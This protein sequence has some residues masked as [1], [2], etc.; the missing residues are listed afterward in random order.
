MQLTDFNASGRSLF[1]LVVRAD[2]FPWVF[3]WWLLCEKPIELILKQARSLLSHNMEIFSPV[4]LKTGLIWG[5]YW[6]K[7]R[8]TSVICTYPH[9]TWHRD[10]PLQR[11]ETQQYY[12]PSLAFLGPQIDTRWFEPFRSSLFYYDACMNMD[13]H[14]F[15]QVTYKSTKQQNK[16]KQNTEASFQQFC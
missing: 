6:I 10:W 5:C 13:S 15:T 7:Q 9:S 12:L 3:V 16:T 4:H 11:G 14:N 2:A 8:T 1:F